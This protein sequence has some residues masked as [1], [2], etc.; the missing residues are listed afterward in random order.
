MGPLSCSQVSV[1]TIL[2]DRKRVML[3]KSS[4]PMRRLGN[5]EEIAGIALKFKVKVSH[6]E[7]FLSSSAF[8]LWSLF[9][10]QSSKQNFDLVHFFASSLAQ[11]RPVGQIDVLTLTAWPAVTQD[12]GEARYYSKRVL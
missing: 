6:V 4:V 11:V 3:I 10:I 12:W 7:H 2:K 8:A 5:T 9:W 1:Q